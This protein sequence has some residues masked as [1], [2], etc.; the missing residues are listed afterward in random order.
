M[1]NRISPMIDSLELRAIFAKRLAIHAKSTIPLLASAVADESQ[2][3]AE[4]TGAINSLIP[5]FIE[6]AILSIGGVT[7]E[8]A[9]LISESLREFQATQQALCNA[10]GFSNPLQK[11]VFNLSHGPRFS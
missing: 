5:H 6:R 8:I 7:E 4:L 2:H 1:I 10:A 3:F 11:A 9:P